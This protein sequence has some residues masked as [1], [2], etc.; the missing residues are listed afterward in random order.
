MFI[1]ER[2]EYK[3]HNKDAQTVLIAVILI[4]RKYYIMKNISYLISIY[5]LL[6]LRSLFNE[7]MSVVKFFHRLI[8]LNKV[9]SGKFEII[10]NF[11][12]MRT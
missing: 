8:F 4:Y 2:N 7:I 5:C 10:L 3:K 6:D 1:N 11:I 9:K 12:C